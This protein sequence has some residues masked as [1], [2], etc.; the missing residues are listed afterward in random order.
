MLAIDVKP[1]ENE[2]VVGDMILSDE[3]MKFLYTMNSTQRLGLALPFN[4]W[5]N[6][7]VFYDV[8]NLVDQKGR[9]VVIVAMEYIQNVSCVRFRV[10]DGTTKNYVL[11]KSGKACSSR[12]GMRRGAQEMIVDGSSCSKGN[13]VHELLHALGFLHMHT[14]SNRDDY[15]KVN[16]KNI[17]DG[18]KLNFKRFAARVSM[19]NT[20]YDYDSI[21]HYSGSAFAKDKKEPTIIAKRAAPNMGQ[22]KGEKMN[23]ISVSIKLNAQTSHLYMLP[24]YISFFFLLYSFHSYRNERR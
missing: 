10:K 11:I 1:D 19:F 2:I 18:Y 16:W 21:T 3:Q 20:E 23:L 9:D 22:R 17:R 6:A 7:T 24:F 12:V 5:P 4:R 8:E 15:I 14:S 13:V